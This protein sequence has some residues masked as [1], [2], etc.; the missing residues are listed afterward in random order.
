MVTSPFIEQSNNSIF[1]DIINIIT[2][3]TIIFSVAG[4]F[5]NSVSLIQDGLNLTANTMKGFNSRIIIVILISLF[6]CISSFTSIK[7]GIRILSLLNVMLMLTLAVTVFF[8][9]DVKNILHI[10][11][12]SIKD[13]ILLLP[14]LSFQLNE[15]SQQWSVDWTINYFIWWCA[16]APFVGI[17][18]AKI[19]KGRTVRQFILSVIFI[20]TLTSMIWFS[21]YSGSA[22]I[23]Y[24][25]PVLSATKKDFTYG[26]FAF[27]EQLPFSTFLSTSSIILLSL[28]IIT[29]IDSSVNTI[30]TLIKNDKRRI[31]LLYCLLISSLTI[32]LTYYNDINLNKQIA[33]IGAIPFMII[34]VIQIYTFIVDVIFYI[35]LKD[36]IKNNPI[37]SI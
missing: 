12:H 37:K 31:T 30:D 29:S 34:I 10:F 13:Y 33:I 15:K 4:A 28:F 2:V 36:R 35:S 18:L 3:F 17:F 9:N 19:S 5:A 21:I 32:I 1:F 16:W 23:K 25:E 20:P 26:L 27:Y 24:S 14:K 8:T 6:F 22:L 7:K 11:M